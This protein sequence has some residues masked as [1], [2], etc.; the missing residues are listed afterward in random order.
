MRVIL[1]RGGLVGCVYS[2][3]REKIRV[4][5]YDGDPICSSPANPRQSVPHGAVSSEETEAL[6]F[7][8]SPMALL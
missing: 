8:V 5:D 6:D 2:D 7:F 4:F 1:V 3:R